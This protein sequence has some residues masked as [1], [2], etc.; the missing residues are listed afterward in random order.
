MEG[1]GQGGSFWTVQK[2][3][4]RERC[5][6]WLGEGGGRGR[7][8][9]WDWGSGWLWAETAGAAFFCHS[10]LKQTSAHTSL[11]AKALLLPLQS[12]PFTLTHRTFTMSGVTG[13]SMTVFV[14]SSSQELLELQVPSARMPGPIVALPLNSC[15]RSRAARPSLTSR[16]SFTRGCPSYRPAGEPLNLLLSSCPD[17]A[18]PV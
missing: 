15:R 18:R 9:R 10:T 4:K 11:C 2:L 16:L 5:C 1:G 12:S 17:P 3:E 14:R 7:G 6:Q 13:G 8:L